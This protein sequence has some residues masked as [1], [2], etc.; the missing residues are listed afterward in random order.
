MV[1]DNGCFGCGYSVIIEAEER[2]PL[3]LKHKELC[4]PMI[5]QFKRHFKII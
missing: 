5:Y 4:V 3:P 2:D 1:V